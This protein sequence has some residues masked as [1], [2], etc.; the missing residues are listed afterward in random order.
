MTTRHLL[1]FFS[2]LTLVTGLVAGILFQV[3]AIYVL[4]ENYRAGV[5]GVCVGFWFMYA[6]Q[7]ALLILGIVEPLKPDS[8]SERP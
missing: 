8:V 6:C 7:G 5:L 1:L 3:S 4:P 2:V